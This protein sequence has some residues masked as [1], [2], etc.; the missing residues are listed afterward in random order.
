M[1][2]NENLFLEIKAKYAHMNPAMKRIADTLLEWPPRQ[3]DGYTIGELAKR[4]KVSNATVTRFVHYLDFDNYKSFHSAMKNAFAE[5][6]ALEGENKERPDFLFAGGFPSERDPES[7]CRYVLKSEIEMLSDTLYLLD[8]ELMEK[9][10]E[11]I[12]NARQ[13]LFFGEGYSYLAAQSA[14]MRFRRLGV[15]CCAHSDFHGMAAGV[16]MAEPEDIIVGISNMGGS[17]PV[18]E[19]LERARRNG[20]RTVAITSVKGSPVDKAAEIS[21]LTGFNYGSFTS[22]DHSTCYEPGSENIPQYSIIDCLYLICVTKSGE[23]FLDRYQQT[24]EMIES[25]RR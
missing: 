13:I 12:L 21:L 3:Q 20:V 23:R 4:S 1:K 6:K 5:K 15:I 24:K 16:C 19:C 9:V 18:T 14:C 7:V 22:M 25:K 10:A 8:F 17:A 11:M 2:E